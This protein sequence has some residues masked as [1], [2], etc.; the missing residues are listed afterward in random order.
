MPVVRLIRVLI[1]IAAVLVVLSVASQLAVRAFDW[2]PERVIVQWVNLDRERNLPTTFQ[3]SLFFGNA[4]AFAAVALLRRLESDRWW[5]HW[6][7]LAILTALLGWDEIAEI[8]ERLID[9]L[10]T[11]FGWGGLLFF[12]WVVPAA[13]AVVLVGFVYLRFLLALDPWLRK[14]FIIAAAL[15]LGGAL[16]ME[17]AGGWYYERIDQSTD[18]VYV[19]LTT[20]EESLE[21]SAL[22][23]LLS[24]LLRYLATLLAK[25]RIEIS[26]EPGRVLI[27]AFQAK[28]RR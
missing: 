10:R 4:L 19:M 11:A 17:A 15:L 8:H 7:G 23:L 12:G 28:D 9:P 5:R 20:I 26:G 6:L 1:A 3:A 16:G 25:A 22:I 27:D 21:M 14:R 2:H 24:T 18:M 13:A